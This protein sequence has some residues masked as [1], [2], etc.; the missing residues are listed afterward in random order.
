MELQGIR[1]AIN[2]SDLTCWYQP[3]YDVKSNVLLGYEALMRDKKRI[4]LNPMEVF[5][6]AQLLGEHNILDKHLI[7][8]AQQLF[9]DFKKHS[10]FINIF[11]STLLQ[12][13]F[14]SWWDKHS[15]N[16]PN[17]VLELSET[18]RIDDWELLKSTLEQ[19]RKR[20][21]KFAVDD[22]GMGY[23][24]FQYWIELE[25]E[26]IKLDKYYLLNA[27]NNTKKQRIIEGLI[28]LV[29]NSTQ[30]IVEGVEDTETLELV[31]G[32]G[33]CYAQGYLLGM[34]SPINKIDNRL[35]VLL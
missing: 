7:I 16:I 26:Y 31:K 5:Q 21:V 12:R 32:L 15:E 27:V 9:R 8:K 22:M 1:Q 33:A 28:T 35:A 2:F 17:I 29:E 30:I 14:I 13:D 4:T 11:P 25:P 18:E 23:T 6:N 3:I 20:N 19:L 34:P 24:S 10:L